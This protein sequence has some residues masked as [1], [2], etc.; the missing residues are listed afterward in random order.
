MSRLSVDLEY[1]LCLNQQGGFNYAIRSHRREG[2]QPVWIIDTSGRDVIWRLDRLTDGTPEIPGGG[3]D[4]VDRVD[5]YILQRDLNR[6]LGSF[7]PASASANSA[8]RLPLTDS[9]GT[10]RYSGKPVRPLA[11]VGRY[12]GISS[13]HWENRHSMP[14]FSADADDAE[15]H[16]D[17][18][19]TP[20]KNYGA[21]LAELHFGIS[22]MYC[23]N[24]VV[25]NCI[26]LGFIRSPL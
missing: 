5:F 16:L 3:R 8:F 22:A 23:V 20:E 4:R 26:A 21:E 25:G 2:G 15:L 9:R 17:V 10:E 1:V 18:E 6:V 7:P 11:Q 19:L 14:F 13:V 12:S 24:G